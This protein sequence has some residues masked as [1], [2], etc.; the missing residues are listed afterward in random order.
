MGQKQQFLQCLLLGLHPRINGLCVR[1][2]SGGV[3]FTP[4]FPQTLKQF[5]DVCCVK[6]GHLQTQPMTR[7]ERDTDGI[8]RTSFADGTDVAANLNQGTLAVN[9]RDITCDLKE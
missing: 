9:G 4:E 3:A 2:R 5:Y 7:W 8:E 6:F 1:G